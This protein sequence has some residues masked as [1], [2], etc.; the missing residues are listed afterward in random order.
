MPIDLVVDEDGNRSD[1][2]DFSRLS[3]N[4][5][6][7]VRP[8]ALPG[9]RWPPGLR[10]HTNTLLSLLLIKVSPKSQQILWSSDHADAISIR[11]AGTPGPSSGGNTSHS[12]EN[13]SE[14]GDTQHTRSADF[15]GNSLSSVTTGDPRSLKTDT[16]CAH[17]HTHAHA[18]TLLAHRSSTAN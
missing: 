18:N 12:G 4:D 14:Q 5:V 11:L 10:V 2:E 1:S 13:N 15:T 16:S 7:Q 3:G 9:Q 6:E 17:T 8:L